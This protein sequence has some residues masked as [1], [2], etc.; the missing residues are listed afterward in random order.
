MMRWFCL[1]ALSSAALTSVP[2]PLLPDGFAV[3][4]G[5]CD[6]L[7]SVD[8][9]SLISGPSIS[10]VLS[11]DACFSVLRPLEMRCLFT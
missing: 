8:F 10:A 7:L 1:G 2:C 6:P 5:K 4:L 9:R 3:A 11:P